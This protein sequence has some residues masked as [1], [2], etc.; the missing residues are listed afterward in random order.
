[1]ADKTISFATTTATS[2]RALIKGAALATGAAAMTSS[3]PLDPADAAS[4]LPANPATCGVDHIVVL[5]QEN[6]SFDHMLGWLP[7]A[8]GVQAGRSFVDTQGNTQTSHHLTRFQNCS[9]GDP[10][11]SWSGGRTQLAGGAMNGFLKT[12]AAG[13]TFPI[14]YFQA[15]DLAFFAS[16]AR[17]WTICDTYHCGILGPTYPNRFYIHSGQTDRI[18]NTA[19]GS[20]LPTIWDAAAA[21]GI[22]AR[23]YY[24]DAAYTA[25][26]GAKY[27]SISKPFSQFVTDAAGGDLPAISYVDPRFD[28]EGAGTSTDD[29]PLADVRNGQVLMNQV[30]SVLSAAPTW[31]KTLFI[32]IYDEWGG[33]ADHVVP[34]LAPV[35]AAEAAAGN[36]DVPGSSPLAYLGFRVPCVLIG[37]RAYRG[38]VAHGAYDPNAI[39]NF[40]CWRFGLQALGVRATT[41][42]NIGTALNWTGTP[43]TALPPAIPTAILQ[44]FN[45][46]GPTYG[47]SCATNPLADNEAIFKTFGQHFA[48]L[49]AL[50]RLMFENGF[51][52]A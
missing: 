50:K 16:A 49:D 26:W 29:H 21:G 24:Q 32:V 15:A 10:D 9:S 7:G 39:L 31:P 40:M 23:Y 35:S 6:R 48:D 8:N 30:Y 47:E 11:H 36:V 14:G 33:F 46:A 12:A 44:A 43:N 20:A 22:T 45:P 19:V 25:L 34:A 51:Q 41:S 28:G 42:G 13:D 18:A 5:M 27:A 4:S 52:R 1:M 37:P 38:T 2:R 17:N 3:L